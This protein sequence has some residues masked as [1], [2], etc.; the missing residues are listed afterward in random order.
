M[1]L[2]KNQLE[3]IKTKIYDFNEKYDL[4]HENDEVL[5]AN[6]FGNDASGVLYAMT[7][8]GEKI[9]FSITSLTIKIPEETYSKENIKVYTDFWNKLGIETIIVP[10]NIHNNDL[11][12]DGS[13]KK[14]GHI[15][16]NIFKKYMKNNK[17]TVF[18]SGFSLD[19]LLYYLFSF[20]I[21]SDF[22]YDLK[23]ILNP[24]DLEQVQRRF[25]RYLPKILTNSGKRIILPG[26]CLKKSEI[27]YLNKTFE[28]PI[29]ENKCL[30]IVNRS[31]AKFDDLINQFQTSHDV[32]YSYSTIR[33]IYDI[34]SQNVDLS[35]CGKWLED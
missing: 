31:R 5:F 7:L 1:S 20:Q 15:R 28:I 32:N 17:F 6:S 26:L 8:L 24:V 2:K 11:E 23:R 19:D 13:C 4:I 25:C 3:N 12:A 35:T 9:D 21:L 27:R 33:E 30:N 16:K 10:S 18:A 29:I 34:F 14:C 22:Q